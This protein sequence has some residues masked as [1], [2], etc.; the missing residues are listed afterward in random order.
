MILQLYVNGTL[1]FTLC[2][3]VH[4]FVHFGSFEP[5]TFLYIL[6]KSRPFFVH[7]RQDWRVVT[8]LITCCASFSTILVVKGFLRKKKKV[9]LLTTFSKLFVKKLLQ[10]QPFPRHNN[11]QTRQIIYL[12]KHIF[13]KSAIH[14]FI[15]PNWCV[16][17]LL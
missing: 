3:I 7:S 14:Q 17:K 12:T 1:Y 5:C 2:I 10:T 16:Y 11:F 4:F 9:H 15:K 13:N 6:Q 8:L